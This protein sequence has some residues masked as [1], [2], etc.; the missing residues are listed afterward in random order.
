MLCAFVDD[1]NAAN[2]VE[3]LTAATI[4][5]AEASNFAGRSDARDAMKRGAKVV[6]LID[7]MSG[8]GW[9]VLAYQKVSGEIESLLTEHFHHGFAFQ[10]P[11][12]PAT[13]VWSYPQRHRGIRGKPRIQQSSPSP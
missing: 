6:I 12:L 3:L 10:S 4:P 13:I 9:D 11:H 8:A 5:S 7:K 2:V 1:A